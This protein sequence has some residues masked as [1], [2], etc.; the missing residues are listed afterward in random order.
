M[1]NYECG[2]FINRS[3]ASIISDSVFISTALVGSSKIKI[4][5][6][7]AKALAN[8]IRWRS[9]PE[10]IEPRSPTNVSYP[11]GNSVIKLC[12]Y[13]ASY[14]FMPYLEII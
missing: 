9:P 13:A 5:A 12:P 2:S 14:K 8:D 1:G 3:V 6:F 11:S 7:F 10:S 4:G